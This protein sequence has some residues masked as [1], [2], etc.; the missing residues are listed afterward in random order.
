MERA[1]QTETVK[2]PEQSVESHLQLFEMPD[3]LP[4]DGEVSVCVIACGTCGSDLR[5]LDG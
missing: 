4:G 1:G 5:G 3:P 2:A